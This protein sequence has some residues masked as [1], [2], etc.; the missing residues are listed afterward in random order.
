MSYISGNNRT[1]IRDMIFAN[2]INRTFPVEDALDE[3]C[4]ALS[5]KYKNL[6]YYITIQ[7]S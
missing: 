1:I 7:Q 4:F 5:K 6:S 2:D 3:F